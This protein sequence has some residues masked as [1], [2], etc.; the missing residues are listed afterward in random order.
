MS[1]DVESLR[2]DQRDNMPLFTELP[3]RDVLGSPVSVCAILGNSGEVRA[4][5]R[6]GLLLGAPAFCT[7][8]SVRTIS[9][10]LRIWYTRGGTTNRS[11]L[12]L[13]FD[14]PGF[15]T[16]SAKTQLLLEQPERLAVALPDQGDQ[17]LDALR[18]R[19]LDQPF[20]QDPGETPPLPGVG[21]DGGYLR[22]PHIGAHEARVS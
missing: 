13:Q 7:P 3:R 18:T 15:D 20:H 16:P 5:E 4:K 21:H 11:Q 6:P 10:T 8:G 14:Q 19:P 2:V 22:D 1:R 17:A 9:S 12:H